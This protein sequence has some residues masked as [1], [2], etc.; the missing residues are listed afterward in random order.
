MQ[1][2]TQHLGTSHPLAWWKLASRSHLIVH[3]HWAEHHWIQILHLCK[4]WSVRMLAGSLG[5]G[6]TLQSCLHRLEAI[7]SVLAERNLEV[8][9]PVQIRTTKISEADD[10]LS[11]LGQVGIQ[12]QLWLLSNLLAWPRLLACNIVWMSCSILSNKI[13]AAGLAPTTL[14]TH[15][16][17]FVR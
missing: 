5:S 7:S 4:A 10:F 3:P 9:P 15:N 2:H 8:Y 1:V 6:C 17:S 11:A 13:D 14:I 12:A 16:T